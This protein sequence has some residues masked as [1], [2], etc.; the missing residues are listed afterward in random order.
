MLKIRIFRSVL[1]HSVSPPSATKLVE[2][3]MPYSQIHTASTDSTQL[4]SYL[5]ESNLN[6][7]E[8]EE[9]NRLRKRPQRPKSITVLTLLT[10]ATAPLMTVASNT[11]A[12]VAS[13]WAMGKNL[14][15]SKTA[16]AHELCP[17]YLRY[18][19]WDSGEHFSRSSADWTETASPLPSIPISELS[20]PVV[21]KTINDNPDLFQIVTPIFVDRFEDLLKSH[22]NQPFVKSVCR[23]FREGFWPW[24]DTHFRDY[25]DTLDYSLPDPVNLDEAQFLR[26]QRDHEV[27]KGRFSESFGSK[28]LP[29]MYCMPIFAVTKPH[30]T[31]L[32][33]V[34]DQSAGKFCSLYDIQVRCC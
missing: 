32:R 33:M 6:T 7:P 22:P 8:P 30:S 19:I 21:T 14:A 4:S 29:G 26:N 9:S 3:R 16:L 5:T 20:N 23:G 10:V 15:M 27:F 28:L 17:K 12:N 2:D 25:P 11:P 18:N 31:D 24:A 34:T 1:L 13:T